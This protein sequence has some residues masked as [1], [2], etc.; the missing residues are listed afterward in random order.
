MDVGSDGRTAAS[1]DTHAEESESGRSNA[2]GLVM[3]PRLLRHRSAW[4]SV[5]PYQHVCFHRQANS[6]QYIGDMYVPVRHA[7]PTIACFTAQYKEV[8]AYV[9]IDSDG[10]SGLRSI[11]IMP[12]QVQPSEWVHTVVFTRSRSSI[13]DAE[14]PS[15]AGIAKLQSQRAQSF[16][17][18]FVNLCKFQLSPHQF[19]F[20]DAKAWPASRQIAAYQRQDQVSQAVV[21]ESAQQFKRL[22]ER[23]SL[24][25]PFETDRAE[26]TRREAAREA[27]LEKRMRA[28][29][30]QQQEQQVC[31]SCRMRCRNR[32]FGASF[33]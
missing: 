24:R 14:D 11:L 5:P 7:A 9:S 28:L 16:S 20:V 4:G 6:V 13:R 30:L 32:L 29:R 18:V 3:A 2:C 1:T 10:N 26:V 33:V 27:E 22:F 25:E 23:M 15:P 19:M 8:M 17:A 31:A 21:A 12:I